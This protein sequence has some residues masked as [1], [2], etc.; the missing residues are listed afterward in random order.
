M[1]Q[2]FITGLGKDSFYFFFFYKIF[3]TRNPFSN[4]VVLLSSR[5]EFKSFPILKNL[6]CS[7]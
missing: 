3:F 7:N 2:I 6:F 4:I 5:K 1:F